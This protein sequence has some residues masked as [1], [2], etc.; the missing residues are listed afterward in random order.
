ML[1]QDIEMAEREA[2][3]A[4]I[5]LVEYL[6]MSLTNSRMVASENADMWGEAQERI[7]QL[8]AAVD[9]A[10]EH[11]EVDHYYVLG[12]MAAPS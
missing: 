11:I 10:M 6:M 4:E 5:P 8:E 9:Y 2:A 7:K 3:R 12:N 1:A